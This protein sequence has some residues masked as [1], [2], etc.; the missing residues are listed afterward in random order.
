[1]PQRESLE[2]IEC[3]AC[4]FICCDRTCEWVLLFIMLNHILDYE[5]T[6]LVSSPDST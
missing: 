4:H 5:S 2:I 3:L 1:M 6:Q